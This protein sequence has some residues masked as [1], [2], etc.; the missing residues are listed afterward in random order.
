VR[1]PKG[2]GKTHKIAKALC[3]RTGFQGSEMVKATTAVLALLLL[4]AIPRFALADFMAAQAAFRRGDHPDAY[5]ACK[6]EVD[7]GDAECQVLVGYLFQEGLGVPANA[8]E[9]LRLYQLAARRGLAI[10]QCHLGYAYERGIGVTRNDVAAVGWYQLAAAQ[11][12]PMCEYF[13]AF[14]L[15]EGQ[16]IAKDRTRAVELLKHAADRGYAPAQVELA[17]QLETA[18]GAMRQAV[19]AYMWYLVAARLTSNSK[20]KARATQGQNRL[21]IEFSSAAII[22]A[23][24]AA[25]EWQPVGPRLEFGPLGAR[26]VLPRDQTANSSASPKPVS[27]GSGFFVS[28]E[29]DLITDNHVIEGCR[30]LRIVSDEKS[31][32]ARV[33][34]T[35]VGADLAIL[36]IADRPSDIASFRSSDLERPGEAVIVAGYPLQGLLTS[37]A[38][39]TT[40]IVSALAGPK[41]DKKLIQIT[42]PVQPGNSGGPLVDSQ[43]NVAGVIVSKLNGLRVARAIGSLP[44]NINFAVKADLA[45]ALLDKNSVKYDTASPKAELLET[46]E[47]AEK[48]FKFTAMVQCYK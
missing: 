20:L 43:G 19:R 2:F 48:T 5:E 31:K 32:V 23:R 37:K 16:G 21:I 9:A 27:S 17:Y 41:D 40:G 30:E 35:D 6:K 4:L 39:V 45:R 8:T 24:N 28:H 42:A 13:L 11:G 1:N 26:P 10:A 46:P 29:G 33:I 14:S 3:D 47:I 18:P 15:I 25:A 34:G 22:A 44:E 7:A 38:S 36:R 12:D